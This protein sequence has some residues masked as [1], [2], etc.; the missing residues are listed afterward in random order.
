MAIRPPP[1]TY[2]CRSCGWQQIFFPK[3]DCMVEGRYFVRACPHCKSKE[4]EIKHNLLTQATTLIWKFF[5][6]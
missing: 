1:R 3:S 6:R 4:I 5:P 2:H